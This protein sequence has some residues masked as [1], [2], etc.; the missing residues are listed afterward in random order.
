M[1]HGG[2]QKRDIFHAAS[3]MGDPRSDFTHLGIVQM[4]QPCNFLC[5]GNDINM[6]EPTQRKFKKNVNMIY[7]YINII[8][9]T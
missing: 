6:D 4:I 7:I 3:A 5:N 8:T 2:R 9:H 1:T